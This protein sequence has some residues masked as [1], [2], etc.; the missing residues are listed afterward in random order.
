MT[1][2]TTTI[3]RY[4]LACPGD[5]GRECWCTDSS[6]EIAIV[7]A[8]RADWKPHKIDGFYKGNPVF[9]RRD[10]SL[11]TWNFCIV[12]D[13]APDPGEG[14]RLL[15]K[16]EY[17]GEEEEVREGDEYFC[18]IVSWTESSHYKIQSR[19]QSTGFHYRRRIEPEKWTPKVGDWVDVNTSL[20]LDGTPF[21]LR[22][23]QVMN[24][25]KGELQCLVDG[26]HY[27]WFKFADC[28]PTEPPQQQPTGTPHIATGTEL[29]VCQDI[30]A[31]QQK[32][33]AK[34][35][36]TVESN[37]LPLRAW[38]DHAYEEALDSAVYLRRAME[39]MDK[40]AKG[41]ASDEAI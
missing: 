17:D 25:C 14:Y 3:K 9:L 32:G 28:T 7:Y 11:H 37:G 13:E 29:H 35:G 38:L 15:K 10:G 8:M 31:R 26:V 4:R 18:P 27:M 20:K 21:V 30:A 40:Q 33:I 24:V 23:Q 5:E 2:N 34:Y 12:A 36:T 39:D 22:Q 6:K 16:M 19:N 41:E 1:T